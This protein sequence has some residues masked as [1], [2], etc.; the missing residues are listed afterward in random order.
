MLGPPAIH[1]VL[2][3]V[4]TTRPIE[5]PLGPLIATLMQQYYH[6]PIQNELPGSSL[7]LWRSRLRAS[8]KSHLCSSSIC[9]TASSWASLKLSARV[10]P[11]WKATL[12][13]FNRSVHSRGNV[14]KQGSPSLVLK[15]QQQ[16]H[17]QGSDEHIHNSIDPL[18]LYLLHV[19][20]PFLWQA[21][22]AFVLTLMSTPVRRHLP[23]NLFSKG[24]SAAESIQGE[25]PTGSDCS[26]NPINLQPIRR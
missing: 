25:R 6:S 8:T 17:Q 24:V 26:E 12:A 19:M 13:L 11:A 3:T 21:L 7:T 16:H 14:F 15:P 23:T 18:S 4:E 22:H 9:T 10:R 2:I 1:N 5:S 20:R